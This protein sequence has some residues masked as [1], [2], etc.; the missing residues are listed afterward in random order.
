MIT[1]DKNKH[2]SSE[3]ISNDISETEKEIILLRKKLVIAEEER[4]RISAMKCSSGIKERESFLKKLQE[5][6]IFRKQ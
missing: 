5:T 6:L 4:D 2:I 1:E 3:E